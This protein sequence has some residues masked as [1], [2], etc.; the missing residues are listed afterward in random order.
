MIYHYLINAMI[1]CKLDE[2]EA[3]LEESKAIRQLNRPLHHA[4]SSTGV[5]FSTTVTK[6]T[7]IAMLLFRFEK[8]SSSGTTTLLP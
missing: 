1:Q 6:F 5:Q 4:N 8:R 7:G 3:L 2:D